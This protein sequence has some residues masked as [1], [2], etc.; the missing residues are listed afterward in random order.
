[1]NSQ[2][3]YNKWRPKNFAE[4]VGQETITFTLTQSI[5]GGKLAHSY[6]F[7]GPRGTGKTSTARILAKAINC[8]NPSAGEPCNSC[9]ICITS[10]Q[11]QALDLIEIDAAT[12]RQVS[13]T[14]EIIEKILFMPAESTHK[15]YIIDE[16]HMLSAASF[17]AFLKTLEEPPSHAIFILCTTEAHKLPPTI[18]S[19]CQRF[20][21]RRIP[22]DSIVDRL[23]HIC[24]GEEFTAT[25]E[26]LRIIS[27]ACRGSLRDACN[28][29]EQASISNGKSITIDSVQELL[30]ITWADEALHLV[31]YIFSRNV[32]EGIKLLS[33]LSSQAIDLRAFHRETLEYLRGLL[34]LRSTTD[35]SLDFPDNILS[36]LKSLSS[37]IEWHTIVKCIKIFG[38]TDLLS[39][40]SS[41]LFLELAFIECTQSIETIKKQKDTST[42]E[43]N[44]VNANVSNDSKR[45]KPDDE[46]LKDVSKEEWDSLYKLLKRS[47]G[48]KFNLG[49]LLLDC[50]QRHF[51]GDTLVLMFKNRSNLDRL[52]AEVD[53]P[54]SMTLINEAIASIFGTKHRL[55]L[56]E[57]PQTNI[58]KAGSQGHIVEAA[59]NM[60]G[61]IVA[62]GKDNE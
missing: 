13:D 40:P 12:H 10:N 11:G 25:P 55:S 16:V 48:K 24:K 4:V 39:D 34:L 56:R 37:S 8:L 33:N 14:Q 19:R 23:G 30:G 29:L 6:L 45:E 28:L 41:T 27:R 50:R 49:A 36:N 20:D 43:L 5:T 18:I 26:A 21:F 15:V 32:P 3:L 7:S 52:R 9:H 59:L 60:G 22:I 46:N 53:D 38:Q 44:V 35:V 47:K 17:N 31:N 62:S 57:I 1:M 42:P 2:V 51:E 58:I 54:G 61:K